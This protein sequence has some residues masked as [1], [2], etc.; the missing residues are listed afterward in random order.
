MPIARAPSTSS[1]GWSPTIAASSGR[2]SRS[3]STARKIVG[4]GFTLPWLP[5]EIHASTSSPW[6]R[7]NCSR[8]RLA[9]DTSPMTSPWAR[10][11]AIAGSTSS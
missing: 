3:S 7:E 1:A 4:L 10:S 9:F 2:T 6:W 11:S 8:S 5:E